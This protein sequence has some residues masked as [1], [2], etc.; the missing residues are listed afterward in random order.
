MVSL[1]MKLWISVGVAILVT[2]LVAVGLSALHRRWYAEGVAAAVM[3][4]AQEDKDHAKEAAERGDG[5]YL[6]RDLM[7]RVRKPLPR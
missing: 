7:S 1:K 6:Y 4:H 5:D 2:A 3:D